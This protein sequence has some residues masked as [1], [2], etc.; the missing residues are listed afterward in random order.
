MGGSHLR[1]SPADPDSCLPSCSTSAAWSRGS[2]R[3]GKPM[4]T[5]SK[6]HWAHSTWGARAATE[7]SFSRKGPTPAGAAVRAG[8]GTSPRRGPG[9]ASSW[10]WLPVPS[11]SSPVP[12]PL[13]ETPL[14]CLRC[15][16]CSPCSPPSLQPLLLLSPRKTPPVFLSPH[17]ASPLGIGWD[18]SETDRSCHSLL[19]SCNGPGPQCGRGVHRGQPQPR[20]AQ[21]RFCFSPTSPSSPLMSC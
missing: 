18:L 17:L 10:P 9:P 2:W 13:A 5:H 21:G 4:T 12:H 8:Q 20:S 14:L 3:P 16:P 11:P 15:V 7:G 6:D 19:E 1:G